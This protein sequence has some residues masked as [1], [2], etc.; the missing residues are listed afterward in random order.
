MAGYPAGL[1]TMA[2]YSAGLVH[3]KELLERAEQMGI[4]PREWMDSVL[5]VDGFCS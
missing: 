5:K 2:D 4:S 1:D 3:H